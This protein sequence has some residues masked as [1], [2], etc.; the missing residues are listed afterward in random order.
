MFSRKLMNNKDSFK[1]QRF[2]LLIL[3]IVLSVFIIFMLDM[4]FELA[5]MP[6][7]NVL[8]HWNR[9][10][11]FYERLDKPS[12]IELTSKFFVADQGENLAIL[13][14]KVLA[15]RLEVYINGRL[16]DSFGDI[17]GNLWPRAL[18][19]EIPTWLLKTNN[20]IKL[21]L[22]GNVGYGLSY[23]PIIGNSHTV[24]IRASIINF[25]RNDIS[26]I[27]IG[28]AIIVGYI[29]L[30]SFFVVDSH[31]R[32][33]YFY[34]GVAM[35]FMVFSLIQFVYRESS[36]S[37]EIYLLFE[38]LG[39]ILPLFGLI[40]IYFSL[41]AYKHVKISRLKHVLFFSP[42]L[43]LAVL[44]FSTNS[45]KKLNSLFQITELFALIIVYITLFYV[46][47]HKIS[48]YYFP[49]IF[50]VFTAFQTLYVLLSGSSNELFLVYGRITFAVYIGTYTIRRF[51]YISEEKKFLEKENLLD[52]LTGAYNRKA[53]ELINPGGFLIIL[54]LDN[55]KDINDKYGHLYGDDILKKFTNI[56]KNHVRNGEDY[57]VRLGGDEFA[58]IT[59]SFEPEKLIQRIY[60]TAKNELGL[61]FSWGMAEFDNFDEAYAKADKKLYE[62]KR[63][64]Q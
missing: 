4:V 24:R 2:Y 15:N 39:V 52:K 63:R 54:D 58:I 40:F 50:L 55:F 61:S 28:A 23:P 25:L 6:F 33:T 20:E 60:N 53:I 56:V 64:K 45:S 29:L 35:I 38:K 26:L 41:N 31:E 46:V 16:V 36:I 9:K 21:I 30:F 48:E 10:V 32:M 7:G 47:R 13:L 62:E 12:S 43:V 51:K 57:L 22:Y 59:R 1:F 11:P 18:V 8:L 3:S 37:R 14:P 34:A 19:Y 27:A 44:M 42:P 5:T 17:S 49:T